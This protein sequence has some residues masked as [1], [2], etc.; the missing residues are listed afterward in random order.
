MDEE[1]DEWFRQNGTRLWQL[2]MQ[3]THDKHDAE[4]VVHACAIRCWL[5][6]REDPSVNW[7]AYFK[8]CIL[9]ASIDHQ[10]KKKPPTIDFPESIVD[11]NFRD[12][13][14]AVADNELR[15]Q[16]DK[17]LGKLPCDEREIILLVFFEYYSQKDIAT[18]MGWSPSTISMKKAIALI[19][20]RTCLNAY[21]TGA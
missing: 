21:V 19:R 10:R 1:F 14:E 17:C 15:E 3:L 9:N 13:A 11:M 16:L 4:D 18:I 12:L 5:K 20:L 7:L 6:F 2:A 8:K